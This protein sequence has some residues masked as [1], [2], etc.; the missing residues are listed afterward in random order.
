M[1]LVFVTI[2]LEK[3]FAFSEHIFLLSVR[4]LPPSPR[5]P[6]PTAALGVDLAGAGPKR[7]TEKEAEFAQSAPRR[8][9]RQRQAWPPEFREP[10]RGALRR[11]ACP[12]KAGERLAPRQPPL[13]LPT[14]SAAE[15][16]RPC[17]SPHP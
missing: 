1:P 9:R 2:S 8:W 4:S 16:P 11:A 14:V 3:T 13:C 5:P 10:G 6:R 7:W 15:P 17:G 12:A